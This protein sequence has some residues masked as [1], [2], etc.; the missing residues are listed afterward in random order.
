MQ[1]H[2]LIPGPYW[3]SLHPCNTST[4]LA[5]ALGLAADQAQPVSDCILPRSNAPPSETAVALG[6]YP[7]DVAAAHCSRSPK[8][9]PANVSQQSASDGG[10]G[11]VT[12]NHAAVGEAFGNCQ[13]TIDESGANRDQ[14]PDLDELFRDPEGQ[15]AEEGAVGFVRYGAVGPPGVRWPGGEVPLCPGDPVMLR[16]YMCAWFSLAGPYVGLVEGRAERALVS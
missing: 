1:E 14:V 2:P 5:L 11:D 7:S 10:G 4:V 13:A 8:S 3:L 12:A 6:L 9:K 16:R 15:M